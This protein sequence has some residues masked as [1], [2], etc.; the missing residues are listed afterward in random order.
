MKRRI[1]M[2]KSIGIKETDDREIIQSYINDELYKNKKIT[3]DLIKRLTQVDINMPKY[4]E[5]NLE[6]K[7]K[8]NQFINNN[9]GDF[10]NLIANYEKAVRE[11]KLKKKLRKH[12]IKYNCE[13]KYCIDYIEQGNRTLPKVVNTEYLNYFLQNRGATSLKKYVK[14]NGKDELP[15]T[16]L[17]I[18]ED[19]MNNRKPNCYFK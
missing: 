17:N 19:I 7:R 3:L 5:L 11:K 16:I 4:D 10:D 15:P 9:N 1:T 13:S 14:D 2:L 18:Y 12:R 8:I 6:F